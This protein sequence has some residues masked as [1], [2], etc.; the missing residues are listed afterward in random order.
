V[1]RELQEIGPR[2]QREIAGAQFSLRFAQLQPQNEAAIREMRRQAEERQAQAEDRVA[3]QLEEQAKRARERAQRARE[4]L[5]E[6]QQAPQP[7][8][9]PKN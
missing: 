5:K 2:I 4:N 3:T 7:T 1:A 9:A 8:P 6:L